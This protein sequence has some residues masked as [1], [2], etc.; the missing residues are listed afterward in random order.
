MLLRNIDQSLGICNGTHLVITKM[1]DYVLKASVIFKS[2][3]GQKVYI[4]RLSLIASDISMDGKT[5]PAC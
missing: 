2:N 5:G 1:V 3:F 4:P